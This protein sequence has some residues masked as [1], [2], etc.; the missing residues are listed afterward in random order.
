MFPLHPPAEQGTP[1]P[2]C[3]ALPAIASIQQA[4]SSF[5]L[6]CC[7]TTITTYLSSCQKAVPESSLGVWETRDWG[8]PLNTQRQLENP[9]M[10]DSS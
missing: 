2:A 5:L 10:W 3:P 9:G 4:A 7:P 6:G 1:L 8:N